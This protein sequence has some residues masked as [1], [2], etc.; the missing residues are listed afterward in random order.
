LRSTDVQ[1]VT[2]RRFD[3]TP[4]Q[5]VRT[6]RQSKRALSQFDSKRR[7]CSDP[8]STRAFGHYRDA[9]GDSD[10]DDDQHQQQDEQQQQQQQQQ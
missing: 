1:T 9:D 8:Y 10:T 7:F 2:Y 3:T 6:V 4:A 5:R